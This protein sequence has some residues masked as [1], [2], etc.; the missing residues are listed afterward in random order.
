MAELKYTLR[1]TG[2]VAELG[3]KYWG[4]QY[5][6]GHSTAYGFGDIQ[7][8]N[9]SDPMYCKAPEMMTYKG[10]PY[11]QELRQAR[12]RPVTVETIYTVSE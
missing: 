2:V 3:G 10:S 5:A 8:A 11:V 12:L 6:D 9:I 1:K 4:I 7:D